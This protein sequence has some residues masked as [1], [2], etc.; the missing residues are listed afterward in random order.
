MYTQLRLPQEGLLHGVAA[1]F[2]TRSALNSSTRKQSLDREATQSAFS[3]ANEKYRKVQF[4]GVNP[5]KS[6]K[7]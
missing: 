2:N 1:V 5:T 4:F 7:Q 6:L 3:V